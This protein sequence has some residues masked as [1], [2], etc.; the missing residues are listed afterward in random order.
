[1]GMRANLSVRGA[2]IIRCR[3]DMTGNQ[4]SHDEHKLLFCECTR[5]NV[6][7]F[8]QSN[9]VGVVKERESYFRQ[10]WSSLEKRVSLATEKQLGSVLHRQAR[11]WVE[12]NPKIEAVSR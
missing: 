1:M 10:N 11:M 12:A 6:V 8:S 3:M 5:S 4:V 9:L 7:H 2:T